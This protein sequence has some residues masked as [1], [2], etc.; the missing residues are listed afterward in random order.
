MSFSINSVYK[1]Y[2]NILRHPKY[3]WWIIIA[4]LIYLFSPLDISPDFLPIV[5]QLD[6]L[7]ILALLV[8][9]VTQVVIEG[10]KSRKGAT[11]STEAGP[12]EDAPPIEVDAVVI[13]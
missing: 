3:R 1:W 13:K 8:S 7:T 9:E 11:V 6:D 4:S 12:S 5:G 2:K 10:Y